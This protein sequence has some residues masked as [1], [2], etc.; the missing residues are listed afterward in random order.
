M[1]L[2]LKVQISQEN[3]KINFENSLDEFSNEHII[4]DWSRND[5]IECSRN[6]SNVFL[7]Q[8]KW[9]LEWKI[10]DQS[11]KIQNNH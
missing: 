1:V 9:D 4:C 8:V 10:K 2:L 5:G 11:S 6:Q 7:G 3:L